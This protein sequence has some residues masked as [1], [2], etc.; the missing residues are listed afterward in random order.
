MDSHKGRI[1]KQLIVLFTLIFTVSAFA[2]DKTIKLSV[3]GMTCNSCA[4]TVE[5]ALKGVNG[6]SEAK[7]D[8]KAKKATI[9]LV[10][11]SK[12]STD[13]L[14]KAVA[15]AGFTASTEKAEAKSEMKQSEKCD[16][17]SGC[18]GDDCKD[19]KKDGKHDKKMKAKASERKS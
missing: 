9:V 17:G 12:T 13:A 6:V 5:K 19:M 15:D 14:V 8:L 10:S 18:C 7:V 16:D 11:N 1:M 4:S 2:G 3:N